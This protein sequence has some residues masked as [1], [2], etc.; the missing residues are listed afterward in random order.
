MLVIVPSSAVAAVLAIVVDTL[1]G[2]TL[3][4]RLRH[5][6]GAVAAA[7]VSAIPVAALVRAAPILPGPGTL[8]ALGR[9]ALDVVVGR[10]VPLLLLASVL[11]IAR[12]HRRPLPLDG[13]LWRRARS[14]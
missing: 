11:V 2:L 12:D 10:P 7:A 6:A 1:V 14:G 13:A 9:R 8:M 3:A 4:L 5:A